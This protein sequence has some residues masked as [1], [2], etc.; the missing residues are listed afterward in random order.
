MAQASSFL[1]VGTVDVEPDCVGTLFRGEPDIL[2]G[3]AL[4]QE[5]SHQDP[6]HQEPSP[7]ICP[8]FGKLRFF[9]IDAQ[10]MVYVKKSTRSGFRSFGIGNRFGS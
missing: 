9:W 4:R 8:I 1:N 5:P 3:N 10:L 7:R 2:A 6:S